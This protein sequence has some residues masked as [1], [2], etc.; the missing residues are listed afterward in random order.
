M[1]INKARLKCQA[2]HM[3]LN[4]FAD[5]GGEHNLYDIL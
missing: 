1:R 5:L 4:T 2:Y 3:C